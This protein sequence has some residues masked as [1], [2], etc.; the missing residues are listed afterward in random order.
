MFHEDNLDHRVL[1]QSVDEAFWCAQFDKHH[2][3]HFE[4]GLTLHG[5]YERWYFGRSV[6]RVT[7][8]FDVSET[9]ETQIEATLQH[10]T[11]LAN[12]V[13]QIELQA[14]TA[15]ADVPHLPAARHG[16]LRPL[17]GALL[18]RSAAAKGAPYGFAQAE[19]LRLSRFDF[20]L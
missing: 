13:R 9:I 6:V 2:P 12:I 11:M 1:A 7:H 16:D 18:R 8:V 3:E 17:I 14:A 15:G 10:R 5:V 20:G 4:E 19:T